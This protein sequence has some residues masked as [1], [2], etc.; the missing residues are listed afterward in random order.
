MKNR[1]GL[2]NASGVCE[3]LKHLK[4][5]NYT[6]LQPAIFNRPVP[7]FEIIPLKEFA[8]TTSCKHDIQLHMVITELTRNMKCSCG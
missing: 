1:V 5:G 3:P 8:Y 7:V 6:Q 2:L 4:T